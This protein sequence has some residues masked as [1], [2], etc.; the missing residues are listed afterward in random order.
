MNFFFGIKTS[1]INS[2]ISIPKFQNFGKIDNTLQ[3]FEAYP[4]NNKWKINKVYCEENKDF[5]FINDQIE[6]NK[7]FFLSNTDE[8]KKYKKNF[9]E[10][11]IKLNFFTDTSP[12]F[13]SNLKISLINGGY[14]SYQSE[15]PYEMSRKKGNILSPIC[16][17]LNRNADQNIIYFKNIFY[18]PIVEKSSMYFINYKLRKIIDKID[19]KYN[20]LNEINIKKDLINNDIYLFTEECLGIPLFVSIKNFQISFE[21]THPP[22]HYI[23]SEDR[24]KQIS[25]IKNDFKDIIKK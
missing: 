21:L 7:I 2:I 23:L 8:I 18:K 5:F 24:Y 20:Y 22:H 1:L 17:L 12:A 13:R 6:N 25:K 14:S 15:Y 3:V 16:M 10:E 11:L 19:I 4:K 9:Y